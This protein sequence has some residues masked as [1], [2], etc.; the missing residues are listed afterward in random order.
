[1]PQQYENRRIDVGAVALNVIDAGDGPPVLLLH[2][3]P[4]RASMWGAQID[5]LV[6]R[7]HRVIAPDLR[8]F[9]D[10]DRPTGVANYTMDKLLGD[11]AG[12]LNVLG[13]PRT[14]VVAHDW[15][16]SLAWT[17]AAALPD[18]VTRLAV[19]SVGHPRAFFSVGTRQRALSWYVL[20]FDHVG[21]P[22]SL[23]PQD[24]WLW[25][26]Q[27]AFKGA[28]RQ[29]NAHLDVQ[30]A[31]LERAGALEAGLNYYRANLPPEVFMLEDPAAEL[32]NVSCPVLGIWSD[33]DMALTED[34]MTRS[35][36]YVNEAWHYRKLE[37]VG[38]WIPVDASDE[39]NAEL[40]RFL[41]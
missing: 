39:V 17:L 31:D 40:G 10:S 3:F 13:I 4:D 1:M 2:G 38:H 7:G 36:H 8:G 26:R 19:L 20:L 24:D 32:P 29:D 12:L 15:G 37:G 30:L 22:E 11:I 21:V 33:E 27:W 25:Y 9:G 41:S 35:A 18:L 6:Q 14:A 28:S 16:A 34:Q 23:M 5:Y